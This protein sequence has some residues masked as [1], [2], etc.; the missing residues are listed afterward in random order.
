MDLCVCVSGSKRSKKKAKLLSVIP[1]PLGL[2]GF[3]S[4]LVLVL[5][6]DR[7]WGVW[8]LDLTIYSFSH[9]SDVNSEG[10]AS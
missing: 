10:D 5:G 7:T 3:L 9:F 2:I 1:S 6:C 8:D 4:I